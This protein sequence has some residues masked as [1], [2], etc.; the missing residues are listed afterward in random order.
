MCNEW[1]LWLELDYESAKKNKKVAI[2]KKESSNL[3]H[4]LVQKR[5]DDIKKFKDRIKYM[6]TISL[7]LDVTR[8]ELKEL[9]DLLNPIT[10]R[11]EMWEERALEDLLP[12]NLKCGACGNKCHKFY[13][14]LCRDCNDANE[15]VYHD[16]LNQTRPADI[17]E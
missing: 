14:G 9:Q 7:S 8:K 12:R 3:I 6:V 17:D 4:T 10:S 13:K 1:D 16:S 15:K 11:L 2:K 5:K